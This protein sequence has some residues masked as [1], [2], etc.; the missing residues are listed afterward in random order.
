MRLKAKRQWLWAFN[1]GK[2]VDVIYVDFSKAFDRVNHEVL[3]NKVNAP[4][5]TGMLFRWI[6]SFLVGRKWRVQVNDYVT[7]WFT[8]TSDVPQG[9]VLGPVLFLI[10]I[11]DLPN[12]L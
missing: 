6:R 2:D 12:Q 3:L 9:T 5:I 11:N 8:S 4:G 7:D 1:E 10:H